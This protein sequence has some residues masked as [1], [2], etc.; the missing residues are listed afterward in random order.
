MSGNSSYATCEETVHTLQRDVKELKTRLTGEHHASTLAMG[1]LE[2][3][4]SDL[5]EE[6][7]QASSSSS[8]LLQLVANIQEHGAALQRAAATVFSH[9]RTLADRFDSL[10]S[11]CCQL[12]QRLQGVEGE[13]DTAK[14]N[15]QALRD[16][17]AFLSLL[18]DHITV[19]RG[20]I[21]SKLS[22][23]VDSWQELAV[24]LASEQALKARRPAA[25][26]PVTQDLTAILA[27][28]GFVWS[29]WQSIRVVADAS[30]E[31]FHT[32]VSMGY[33]DTIKAIESGNLPV[34]PPFQTTVTSLIKMLRFNAA[35]TQLRRRS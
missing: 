28:N 14:Q 10:V 29:N 33:E 27:Q 26:V 20:K 17:V 25:P 15:E 13:R 24:Q 11:V 30:I 12:E 31:D 9:S 35:N 21:C 5:C 4:T 6:L 1:Q 23:V 3:S 16:R 8:Q 34:P 2:K 22:F 32:C 19:F 18:R 7:H